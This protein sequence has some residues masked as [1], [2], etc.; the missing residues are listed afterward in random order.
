MAELIFNC[1]NKFPKKK[2]SQK[3]KKLIIIKMADTRH[4]KMEQRYLCRNKL[5]KE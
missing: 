2:K 1:N 4:L 3:F 5:L